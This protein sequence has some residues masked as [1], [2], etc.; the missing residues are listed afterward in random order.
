MTTHRRHVGTV[1]LASVAGTAALL[2]SGVA[3]SGALDVPNP[4]AFGD[5]A[6][7][8]SIIYLLNERY[9][10]NFYFSKLVAT[11]VV[12]IWNFWANYTFTFHN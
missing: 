6:L 1:R 7:N 8:N 5:E 2:L 4:Q 12:M 10:V 3:C 9:R 11:G